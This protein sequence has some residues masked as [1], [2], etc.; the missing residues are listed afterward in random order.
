[1]NI[2]MFFGANR[3]TPVLFYLF[4]RHPGEPLFIYLLINMPFIWFEFFF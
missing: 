3:S 4:F 1:M 2:R